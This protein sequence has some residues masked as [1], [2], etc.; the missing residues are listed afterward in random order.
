MSVPLAIIHSDKNTEDS[1]VST[2]VTIF[3]S[4][5]GTIGII[6]HRVNWQALRCVVADR[7]LLATEYCRPGRRDYGTVGRGR[8][9]KVEDGSGTYISSLKSI[10]RSIEGKDHREG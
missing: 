7:G 1:P 2:Y 5:V 3:P 9:A 4:T 8:F 10:Y 6:Y